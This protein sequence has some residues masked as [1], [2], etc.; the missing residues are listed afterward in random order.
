MPGVL[1][2]LFG[3]LM[4]IL[5]TETSYDYSLYEVCNYVII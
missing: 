1:A 5:A 3:A 4:A 2:A